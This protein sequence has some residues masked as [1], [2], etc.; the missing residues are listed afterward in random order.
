MLR[1]PHNPGR[2]VQLRE[3]RDDTKNTYI[4]PQSPRARGTIARRTRQVETEAGATLPRRKSGFSTRCSRRRGQVL[5]NWKI[6]ANI[7]KIFTNISIK[8]PIFVIRRGPTGWRKWGLQGGICGGK[9]LCW[10]SWLS[11]WTSWWWL[12]LMIVIKMIKNRWM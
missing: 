5:Q 2:G 4:V 3:K 6:F 9:P 7:C 1:Y 10:V 8:L 11:S 12:W